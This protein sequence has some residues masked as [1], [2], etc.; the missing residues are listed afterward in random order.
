M[1]LHH[2]APPKVQFSAQEREH[3]VMDERSQH[4]G[5]LPPGPVCADLGDEC[6]EIWY[7]HETDESDNAVCYR[8]RVCRH[9]HVAWNQ[10]LAAFEGAYVTEHCGENC[11]ALGADLNDLQDMFPPI[12]GGFLR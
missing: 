8:P 2:A 12:T 6:I 10:R 4:A 5:L 3:A 1:R 11:L 9:E 7:S